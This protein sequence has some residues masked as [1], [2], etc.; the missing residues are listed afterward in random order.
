MD[1][2]FPPP[3]PN[4][5]FKLPVLKSFFVYYFC[6]LEC[7][8]HSFAYVAYLIFLRYV[9]IRSPESFRSKQACYN[10]ATHLP[11]LATHLP[12]LATR[13]PNLTT[14]LPDLATHLPELSQPSSHYFWRL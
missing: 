2:N 11:N 5:F 7:V 8:G 10:L 9:W 12:N 13:L 6:G 14:H 1:A 3:P 4:F